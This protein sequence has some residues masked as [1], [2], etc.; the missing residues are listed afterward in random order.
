MKEVWLP[1]GIIT[2]WFV[3]NGWVLP[4]FGVST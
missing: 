1:L 2:A 4:K 3:L